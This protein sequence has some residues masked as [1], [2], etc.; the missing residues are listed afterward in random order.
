MD[1]LLL[2]RLA[3]KRLFRVGRGCGWFWSSALINKIYAKVAHSKST[4]ADARFWFRRS[5]REIKRAYT[6]LRFKLDFNRTVNVRLPASNDSQ[7]FLLLLAT[8]RERENFN[9]PPSLR[10]LFVRGEKKPARTRIWA[11]GALAPALSKLLFHF[12]SRMSGRKARV[13]SSPLS[14]L[15]RAVVWLSDNGGRKSV[16][17]SPIVVRWEKA[18]ISSTH[19]S[20]MQISAIWPVEQRN[21]S[22]TATKFRGEFDDHIEFPPHSL[23]A[24]IERF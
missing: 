12:A 23:P 9:A 19:S 11:N 2:P 24:M 10:F 18:F 14:W 21:E 13:L 7:A 16:E 1:Q 6:T 5:P 17:S 22:E 3:E 8:A 15:S 4:V 20:V